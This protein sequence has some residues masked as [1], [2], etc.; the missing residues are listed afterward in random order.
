MKKLILSTVVIG[1]LTS[2]SAFAF[3][4]DYNF[5]QNNNQKQMQMKEFK[6][7]P[8]ILK[9]FLKSKNISFKEFL[10]FSK[11]KSEMNGQDRPEMNGQNP[12]DNEKLSIIIDKI[13]KSIDERI[14]DLKKSKECLLKVES[15]EELK[16]CRPK[17]DNMKKR[18]NNM[19]K[20][21][22]KMRF[23]NQNN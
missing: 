19:K 14:S 6:I 18:M 7:N 15:K 3:N 1:V 23:N 13:T 21:F 8:N 4:G 11:N 12:F 9:E 2:V 16:D 20:D 5:S 22:K 10:D 17:M